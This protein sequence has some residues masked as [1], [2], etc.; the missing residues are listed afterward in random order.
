MIE[1]G[2]VHTVIATGALIAHGLTESIGLTHY[3]YDPA[4]SDESLFEQGY[5]RVYDTLEMESNLDHVE[6]LVRKVLEQEAP[7]GGAW[8]SSSLCH[9]LGRELSEQCAGPAILRSGV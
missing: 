2:M 8:S 6:V 1:N 4:L 3:R 7:A 9:A 5:N